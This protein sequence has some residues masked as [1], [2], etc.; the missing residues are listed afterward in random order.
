MRITNLLRSVI[1]YVDRQHSGGGIGA[2]ITDLHAMTFVFVA[3]IVIFVSLS[4]Q[5]SLISL[6]IQYRLWYV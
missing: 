1:Y 2:V 4:V 6:H 5:L 3:L